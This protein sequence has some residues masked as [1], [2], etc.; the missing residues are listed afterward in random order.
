MSVNGCAG[1]YP[2]RE[3]GPGRRDAQHIP[4]AGL[5]T[6]AGEIPGGI[7]WKDLGDH[8]RAGQ[9]LL[10]K[11]GLTLGTVTLAA[12]EDSNLRNRGVPNDDGTRA[13]TAVFRAAIAVRMRR[14]QP[15]ASQE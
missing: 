3:T 14:P 13:T 7:Q 4:K 1:S 5:S 6:A 9:D 12:L 8:A 10:A 15:P 11:L 2:N